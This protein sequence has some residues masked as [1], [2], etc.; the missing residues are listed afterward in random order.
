MASRGIGPV[1]LGKRPVAA[2][3]EP[4]EMGA[5]LNSEGNGMELEARTGIRSA[6]K[7]PVYQ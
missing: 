5:T 2:A 4:G 1:Q 6:P 3:V 7:G